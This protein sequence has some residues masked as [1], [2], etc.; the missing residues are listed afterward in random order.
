MIIKYKKLSAA[1]AAYTSLMA[2]SATTFA[3]EAVSEDEKDPAQLEEVTVTGMRQSLET[4]VAIKKNTM[5]IV[6]SITAE[7]IGKLPDPNVAE[8]LTRI[9]GVQG[10]RYGG[11]GASPFGEGS[12]LTIRGLSG[13][14]ASRVD[15]RAYFT[16][17]GRE[18]NIEGAIPGMIAGVDVYKNPSAEHIE[19]GIGGLVNIKTRKPLDFDERTFNV[20]VSNRYND[21]SEGNSPEFF[22]LYADRWQTDFGEMGLMI[23]GNYQESHN[24]SDSDP[25]FA[26]GPQLRRA[27]SADSAEYADL[28]TAGEVDAAYLGR[29]DISYLTEANYADYSEE[30]RA[31][32]I[33]A[34]GQTKQAFQED[35]NRVRKGANV[36]FEWRPSDTLELYATANYNYYL[37]D[38]EYRFMVFGSG[39][40]GDSRYVQDLSTVDYTFDEGFMNRNSNGGANE[41]V[42][43]QRLAGGTFLNTSL[44]TWGGHEDHPYE[45]WNTA[46]GG[47]WQATEKLDVKF[48][49][50]YIQATQEAD[51]RKVAFVPRSGVTWDVTRTL[52]KEPHRLDISGPDLSDPSNFVVR[53]FDN[54]R[55]Q[56][57]EDDGWATQVDFKYQ[58]DLPLIEDI[59]FGARY[60]TQS[61][62][63][64]NFSYWGKPISTDGEWLTEDQSNAV[65][66]DSLAGLLDT[67][68]TNWLDDRAGYSGGYVVYDPRKLEGNR[69]R[70]LFPQAGIP[71]DGEQEE[72][73]LDRRYSEEESLAAYFMVDF[74]YGDIIKGNVGA[75]VV[76]TDLYA[77]AMIV[78]P[79]DEI[80]PNEDGTSYLDVLPSLNVTGYIDEDTLVRF[81]YAKGI[82]RPSLSAL[83]PVVRVDQETGMGSV[84]NPD[85]R[86]LKANSFDVS[87]EKYFSG[88]NYVSLGLFYKDIDGFFNSES[89]CQSI[90][91]FPTHRSPDNNCPANQ[92]NVSRTINA[93]KGMARG[94]ELAF[95]T[96]FDYD[97]LPQALHNFG[98]SG[99][100]T[101]LDT[102][103][104]VKMNDEIVEMPMPFQSDT[105]W[106]L[107]GMYEDDFMSA[108][109]V[110]TYRSE[111]AN[112]ND[113]WPSWGVYTEGYG[114]LDASMNFNLTEDLALSVNASNLTNEAPDRYA[115]DPRDYDSN[116]LIQ[117]FV[118]GRVFGAGLRYS[119]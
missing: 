61:A 27:I 77:R 30:E 106:S 42:A 41:L 29:S 109:V 80:V 69:V 103:N 73:L 65:S 105:S 98:V 34:L 33:T 68:P 108:R 96:F 64:R 44:E 79:N 11:E 83:N 21:L 91:A 101:I 93:E 4:S 67:S 107:S 8:T 112:N 20:A 70:N 17:G 66:A 9:P 52:M 36:T 31:N 43:G 15:G 104:P 117:H 23:A 111:F 116:F 75:R 110:Y 46:F 50:S 88:A 115:G 13:Q 119:F 35:I 24:R 26:R 25:V 1:I 114:I 2:M 57:W 76:Q 38:Q 37:Y 10:Y 95:Q 97:F 54:N 86:P 55:N 16:A 84:G 45:T 78:D 6:D 19:G 74:A 18:F 63:F 118:N 72:H 7:D 99:S 89:T 47:E 49:V 48:D 12:G 113:A 87:L 3:Q 92:Y 53:Y 94:V 40:G 62:S 32:L 14:T 5:E 56:K 51:N 59:K 58:M 71:L 82:T 100:Y 22:G 39:I 60:A 90:S 28:V 85:L 102:E 81:G